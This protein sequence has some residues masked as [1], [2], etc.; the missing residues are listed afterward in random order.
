VNVEGATLETEPVG[1]TTLTF[2]DTDVS[3]NLQVML[4]WTRLTTQLEI[5][6][7][8]LIAYPLYQRLQGET[9]WTLV[10]EIT[11]TSLAEYLVTG[12][13][14]GVNYEFQMRARNV[15]GESDPTESNVFRYRSSQVPV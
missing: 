11:D 1:V 8:P 3:N 13:T 6:G 15:H 4:L 12:L 14:G 9:A 5:G 2:L 7:S 10:E